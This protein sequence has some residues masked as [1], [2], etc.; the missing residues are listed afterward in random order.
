M[1]YARGQVE[2][3]FEGLVRLY[4]VAMRSGKSEQRA[5]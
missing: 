5:D 2:G 1:R 3:G 4:L